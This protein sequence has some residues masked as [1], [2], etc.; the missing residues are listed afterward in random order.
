MTLW[1]R[2]QRRWPYVRTERPLKEQPGYNWVAAEAPDATGAIYGVKVELDG[3]RQGSFHSQ[4][5]CLMKLSFTNGTVTPSAEICYDFRLSPVEKPGKKDNTDTPADSEPDSFIAAYGP[6]HITSSAAHASAAESKSG[7]P[8]SII[9]YPKKDGLL[10]IVRRSTL[11]PRRLPQVFEF[12]MVVVHTQDV[13]LSIIPSISKLRRA[14]VFQRSIVRP[15]RL[16]SAVESGEELNVCALQGEGGCHPTCDDFGQ[17]HMTVDVW[18]RMLAKHD[19]KKFDGDT[20]GSVS[21][22]SLPRK[23]C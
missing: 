1:H 22:L 18:K 11:F 16:D 12:A 3:M 23:R 21:D 17:E 13:I 6:A 8:S 4:P 19:T 14:W 5:A 9:A 10:L 15:I 2:I 20:P 7:R